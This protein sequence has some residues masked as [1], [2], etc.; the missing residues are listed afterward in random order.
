MLLQGLID[1]GKEVTKLE[2]KFDKLTSQV[3]KLEE[4]AGKADYEK[5][6]PEDVRSQNTEKVR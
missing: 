5:K 1:L 4:T 3:K 2:S 6:V